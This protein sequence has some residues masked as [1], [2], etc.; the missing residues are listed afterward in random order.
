MDKHQGAI[1]RPFAG[2]R[3]PR[4]R[5]PKLNVMTETLATAGENPVRASEPDEPPARRRPPQNFLPPTSPVTH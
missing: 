3:I 2:A 1:A 4:R 5:L